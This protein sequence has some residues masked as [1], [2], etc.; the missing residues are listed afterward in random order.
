MDWWA[1][2]FGKRREWDIHNN[3]KKDDGEYS[4]DLG[5][6]SWAWKDHMHN[7]KIQGL[8]F[9]QIIY[10]T[11]LKNGKNT[12][13]FGKVDFLES[14]Y[15]TPHRTKKYNFGKFINA[16]NH[17]SK[18]EEKSKWN[19]SKVKFTKDKRGDVDPIQTDTT[20]SSYFFNNEDAISFNLGNNK[21]N[22]N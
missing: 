13:D 9:K 7:A 11:K 14:K 22:N 6:V 12:V 21:K 4:S 19:P 16:V 1:R 20:D 3:Y 2:E 10:K 8:K 18:D 5:A 15:K 17:D